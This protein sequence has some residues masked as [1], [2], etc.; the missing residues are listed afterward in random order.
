MIRSP[1]RRV[2][3]LAIAVVFGLGITLQSLMAASMSL[4]MATA[5]VSDHAKTNGCATCNRDGMVPQACG[6]MCIGVV[7]VMPSV[8]SM[9][10]PDRAV[11]PAG[12]LDSEVGRHGPPDLHPPKI[13][14]I[15]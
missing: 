1:L 15:A 9:A 7:A 5:A 8:L 13:L 14:S 12:L 3:A 4:E 6:T 11:A 10:A 2:F